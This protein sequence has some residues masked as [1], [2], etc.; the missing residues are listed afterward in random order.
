AASYGRL[1][2]RS[3]GMGRQRPPAEFV[4]A[5]ALDQLVDLELLNQE[6]DRLGLIVDEAELRD[7]I[8][9]TPDFL[10][11]GVFDK[12]HYVQVLQHND[13]KPSDFEQMQRRRMVAGRVQGL[14]RSGVHVS[15]QELQDRYRYENERVNLRFVRVPSKD[16]LNDIQ[17]SDEDLRK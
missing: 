2:A 1:T 9:A 14:V 6:A 15:D 5:Q 4:R 8:K 16:F 10:L 3:R 7:A 13:Y 11:N 12:D 17:L